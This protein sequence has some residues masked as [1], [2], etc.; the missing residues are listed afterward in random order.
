MEEIHPN[1]LEDYCKRTAEIYVQKYSCYL[2]PQAVHKLLIHSH[3]VV[4]VKEFPVGMLSEEAQESSNKNF[5]NFR[6]FFTRKSSRVST[7]L[8]SGL[9]EKT[10][11]LS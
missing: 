11:M 10:N 8:E 2:M 3:Q 7:N 1:R 9:D 4:R 5:K 6:E